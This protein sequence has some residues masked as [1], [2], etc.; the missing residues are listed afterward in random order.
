MKN[1]IIAQLNKIKAIAFFER[2]T[3]GKL[4]EEALGI[5]IKAYPSIA[6]AEK[7]FSEKPT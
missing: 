6:D 7:L 5:Y 4:I 3:I 1:K 2:K